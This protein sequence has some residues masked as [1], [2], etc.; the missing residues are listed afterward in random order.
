[1]TSGSPIKWRTSRK[2]L[3][4]FG[5][6]ISIVAL[7]TLISYQKIQNIDK[8]VVQVVDVAG[9]LE[10]AI[11]EMKI[12]AGETAGA[13]FD[14]VR[15]REPSDK[16]KVRD[17]EIVFGR[18]AAEFDMLAQTDEEKRLGQEVAKLYEESKGSGYE[19]M[20]L[21]DQR[22]VALQIFQKDVKEIGDLIDSRLQTAIDRTA[23]DGMKKLEASLEMEVS[24]DRTFNAI[25]SYMAQPEPSLRQEILDT[26][27]LFEQNAMIYRETP[28]SAY[29][30][31]WLS[32]IDQKF[33]ETINTSNEIITITDTLHERLDKFEQG[34]EGIAAYIDHQ[35][36]PLIHAQALEAIE[37]AK[38]SSSA[39]TRALITLGIIGILIG[40]ISAWVTSR[41][42]IKPL[43]DL[44]R[45]IE[46]ASSGKLEH[47]MNPNA[48]G[49]F[50][51]LAL[52]FNHML[53]GLERSVNT[54]RRNEDT[55][56]T[57]LNAPNDS[58]I[59]V[60]TRGVIVACN[61]V[62]AKRFH[63]SAEEMVGT[64]LYDL[65]PVD[66]MVSRKAQIEKAI[67][68]EQPVHS[69]DE[70][71]GTILEGRIYP[72]FG[73]RGKVIHV[74][75]FTRDIT[76]RKWIEEIAERFGRRNEL[77]LEAAGEGIYGVDA[78]GKTTF[79]NPAAA[80]M[81]GYTPEELIGKSHHEIVHHSKLDGTPYPPEACPIYAALKDGTSHHGDNEVFWRKDGTCFAVEYHSTPMIEDGRIAGAV[82]TYQDVT[83]RKR[84][85]QA[86]RQSEEKYR[87]ISESASTLIISVDKDGLIIDCNSRVQQIL[88]YVPDEIIGH[89]L[90]EIVHSEYSEKARE[91]LK[92]ILT[93]GFEYDNQY[94]MV[95]KDG[96]L[97]D[98]NMNAAAV[99]DENGD[100]VRTICMIDDV[101]EQEQK[102]NRTP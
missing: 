49:E 11:L 53:G 41:G 93:K 63:K 45:G 7:I 100:Y 31:S 85:E 59:L 98:V 82:V 43:R 88:G 76:T 8:N 84:V 5:L 69:E 2:L 23:S 99:R 75:V 89:S 40:I 86:L 13:V 29:E 55:A 39:A 52:A 62:A 12:G 38:K 14:Y 57:L 9:P 77:I 32:H 30:E 27:A 95:R 56:W 22:Y 101:T 102:T 42:I 21:V 34:F 18:I 26:Q 28:L 87:S 47:R 16:E 72:V 17:A 83:E 51:Q 65:L 94:R 35:I 81:L 10:R 37:D 78:Q 19:I 80:R 50:R 73:V 6:L 71:D 97:I 70:R 48:K 92:E 15:D 20:T 96:K 74:A 58:A 24:V 25:E 3:L 4:G 1:M 61:K 54:S 60:D 33:K 67:S 91:S 36:Q 79:V 68:T 44:F 66:L 90:E 64:C 46:I